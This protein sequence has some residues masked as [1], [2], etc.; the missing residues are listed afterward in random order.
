MTERDDP[1]AERPL[2]LERLVLFSDA[3]FAIAI[4]LLVIDLRL[5]EDLEGPALP[6][7]LAAMWP[8]LLAYVLSFLVIGVNWMAHWRR[9][10]CVERADER[11]AW[12]NLAL[13]GCI[14]LMPFPTSV[15]AVH[16]DE[17]AAV[18]LYVAVIALTGVASAAGW[19][20]ADRAGLLR[21]GLDARFVRLSALR[22]LSVPIVMVLSLPLLLVGPYVAMVSWLLIIP[23]QREIGRRLHAVAPDHA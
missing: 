5:P 1:A 22:G 12:L 8:Q 15:L 4:T 7:A 6:E 14:A 23:V 3:V 11:L 13:L 20:Y 2:G 18:G 21:P 9:Y 17:P 16:G 10:G 19:L